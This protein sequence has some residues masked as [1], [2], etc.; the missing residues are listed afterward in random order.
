MELILFYM[1]SVFSVYCVSLLLSN[2]DGPANIFI[3]LR[4]VW[5]PDPL[6]KLFSCFVC[7]SF[8]V[9][10]IFNVFMPFVSVGTF[11]L[12]WFA[13]AGSAIAIY[14]ITEK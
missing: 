9:A 7:L 12:H 13:L 2:Y 10:L 5:L 1:F 11:V 6:K 3:K 8:W 4:E 14:K